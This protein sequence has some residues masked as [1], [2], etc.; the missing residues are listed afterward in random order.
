MVWNS[1]T[2]SLAVA[3]EIQGEIC[4][5]SSNFVAPCSSAW[6]VNLITS[7]HLQQPLQSYQN[8]SKLLSNEVEPQKLQAKMMSGRP[9]ST[10]HSRDAEA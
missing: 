2:L 6:H 1:Y 8:S 9:N 10:R 7:N 5:A 4:C 3:G